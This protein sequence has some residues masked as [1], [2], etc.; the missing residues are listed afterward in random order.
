[1]PYSTD[2]K[3]RDTGLSCLVLLA[4]F[5][6]LAG[7]V[8]ALRHGL[9]IAEDAASVA[10]ILR[11]GRKLGLKLR[12]LESAW[13]RLDRTPLPAIAE[14]RD[15]HFFVL[16]GVRG[17]QV[18]VQDPLEAKP[19][20]LPR[21]IFEQA[22]SGRLILASRRASVGEVG[23]RFGVTWFVPAIRE[24]RRLFGEVLAASFFL[25]LLA[26]LTPL[27]FQVI[28][29]KVLV[30]RG[31]AT[32]DVLAIGLLLVSFFE[33]LLGGLRSYVFS[34]T[35]NRID[36]LLGARLFD[37]LLRLP[38]AYFEAR[39]VGDS[40]A[41]VRELENIRG[42]LT[43]SA[44]TLVIDLFFTLVFFVVLYVYSPV[45]TALVAA[46]VPLYVLLSAIVTPVLRRRVE[47]QF[48]RGADNQ[49]FLVEAVGG[50][51][52]LKSMAVEPQMQRRWEDQLAA[53]ATAGFS[54]TN[55]GNIASQTAGLINK[56]TVVMILWVGATLVMKGELSV[57]QLIAFNM[58]AGRVSGPILRL[59]Q[60]WQDFQQAA[61]SMRRLGDILDTPTEPGYRP[62][63]T[64]L[65]QLDGAVRFDHVSF[66]YGTD[67]PRVLHDITLAIR[68]GEVIG[69]V[70]RSGSGKSTLTKLIQRLYVPESGRLCIDNMDL[71][72]VEPAWLRRQVGVV[73]QENFLFHRS[74]R[75]NIALANPG[76]SM[77]AVI[78]AAKL[79]G[80]H[81]FIL[82]LPEGYDTLI[83]EQGANLSGG[84][85]QRLAIA[86]ALVTNPRVLILDE[87][88][89]AL[90]YESEHRVQQNMR[91]ICRGR[92]VFIIAHRLSAV[93]DADRILVMDQGH[94]IEQG[95]HAELM[96]K[97][98]LYAR[99]HALQAGS[100][101]RTAGT[102][103]RV[104]EGP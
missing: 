28:I 59:V 81:E 77:D 8:D 4:R 73:L 1:M 61:I 79:A 43:G 53:Y 44:L 96:R 95:S 51:Q 30:H 68:P 49:A 42:F 89:S 14:H 35:A 15:G 70:G 47:E 86:R 92:T 55:L 83:D 93:R 24:H 103:S 98:G 72:L 67:G 60:L 76:L 22:W 102:R 23:G 5:H 78:A 71:A 82:E 6:G 62:G 58:I 19:L 94:M 48:N 17:D 3:P 66:R 56:V 10:Q 87:A 2:R 36:V 99:L 63:R 69:I 39:R 33:V 7:D 13:Q 11:A 101:T 27:F 80:A 52:T 45:L 32:L 97:P 57:G 41:R 84:Q 54:A 91:A 75:E 34:H 64:T 50:I 37:H 46:A 26:L 104:G 88:T 85:R 20:T 25:Q 100:R 90:D 16:A 31:L 9:G 65:P 21:D 29:D 40:V 18:L 38:L 12:C 74:V